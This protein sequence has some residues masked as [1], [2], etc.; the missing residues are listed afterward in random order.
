MHR[1]PNFQLATI[2]GFHF[3]A[4]QCVVL[5]VVFKVHDITV[6]SAHFHVIK[7]QSQWLSSLCWWKNSWFNAVQVA[8]DFMDITS[9]LKALS[10]A[11]SAPFGNWD[12]TLVC[13]KINKFYYYLLLFR[14]H[15]WM[16]MLVQLWKPGFALD[17]IN[18]GSWYHCLVPIGIYHLLWEEDCTAVVCKVVCFMEV[19]PG[20]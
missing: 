13:L 10:D 5:E 19:R 6:H 17:G 2:H 8:D 4:Y 12:L 11:A 1:H 14:W 18:S 16:E 9:P 15:V 3:A 20:L 7:Y